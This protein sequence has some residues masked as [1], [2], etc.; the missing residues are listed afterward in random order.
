MTFTSMEAA[1]LGQ[2][3]KRLRFLKPRSRIDFR[4]HSRIPNYMTFTSM[5]A[6]CLGNENNIFKTPFQNRF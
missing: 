5:V 2:R 3:I 6:A 4:L 1:F